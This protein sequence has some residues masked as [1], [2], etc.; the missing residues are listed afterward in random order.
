[1]RSFTF[2]NCWRKKP[3]FFLFNELFSLSSQILR[4]SVR[5]SFVAGIWIYNIHSFVASSCAQCVFVRDVCTN[6][7]WEGVVSSKKNDRMIERSCHLTTLF[8]PVGELLFFIVCWSLAVL[9]R[10]LGGYFD[11]YKGYGRWERSVRAK[12]RIVPWRDAEM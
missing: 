8:H 3:L 7:G 6:F 5:R 4:F 9:R 1:M 2:G 10:P 11:V 12:N